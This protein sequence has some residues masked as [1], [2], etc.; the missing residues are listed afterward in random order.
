MKTLQQYISDCIAKIYR[1]LLMYG[2][3]NNKI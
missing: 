3:I 2:K 1:L